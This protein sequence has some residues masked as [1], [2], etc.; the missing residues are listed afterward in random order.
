VTKA[1]FYADLEGECE[2]SAGI[3]VNLNEYKCSSNSD[4]IEFSRQ[5]LDAQCESEHGEFECS[6]G[7][8]DLNEA[9]PPSAHL[10]TAANDLYSSASNNNNNNNKNQKQP[11][12]NDKNE[13][14]K[15]PN[16]ND[17]TNKNNNSNSNNNNQNTNKNL[18]SYSTRLTAK[19][20]LFIVNFV[21]IACLSV[22]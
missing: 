9:S 13:A 14:T 10:N 8:E 3:K 2:N 7:E 19:S 4:N 11:I 17:N 22:F 5:Y 16:K 6:T 21:V 18:M 15:S 12:G 1:Q 20:S